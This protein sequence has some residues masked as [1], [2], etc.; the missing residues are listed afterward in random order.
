MTPPEAWLYVSKRLDL[1]WLPDVPSCQAPVVWLA[2][3]PHYRLT[4]AVYWW[5]RACGPVLEQRLAGRL[6]AAEIAPAQA[7][8]ECRRYV[9]AAELAGRF[10]AAAF[11]VE[12][13]E[14]W[15]HRP[16][17]LPDDRPPPDP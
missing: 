5:V 14:A 10:V 11:G 8:E 17:Q 3:R 7:V 2:G 12:A 15:R 4:P 13:V 16:P 1:A 6:A 9:E